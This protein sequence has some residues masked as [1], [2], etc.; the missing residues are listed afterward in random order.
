VILS[1][2]STPR[3]YVEVNWGKAYLGVYFF[4]EQLRQQLT[5]AFR[6]I[7]DERMFLTEVSA[8][9]TRTIRPLR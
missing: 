3:R 8:G 9:S 7:D 2:D 4:D 5:Y 6:R 1:E